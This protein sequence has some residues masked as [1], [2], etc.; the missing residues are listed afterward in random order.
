MASIPTT[1]IAMVVVKQGGPVVLDQSYPVPRIE[2]LKPGQVLVKVHYSGVCHSD[3]HLVDDAW[4]LK[5]PYPVVLGHEGA[6]ELVGIGA[7]TTTKL[8]IGDKVG[9]KWLGDSC[10][11]CEYCNKGHEQVCRS[12][13]N[14]GL[15]ASGTFQQYTVAA[16]T[17]LTPIPDNLPLEWAAPLLCAGITVYNALKKAGLEPAEYVAIP[18]AGGGLGHIALQY[19]HAM[20]YRTIAID[21]GADKEKLCKELKASFW[22][23]YKQEKDIVSAIQSITG[24][25]GAH[26]ALVAASVAD[27]YEQALLYIRPRGAVVLVGLPP[28][29]KMSI[30]IFPTALQEKRILGTLTSGRQQ[31]IEAL[32]FAAVAHIVPHIT[33]EPLANIIDVFKRFEENKVTGRIVIKIIQ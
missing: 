17:H 21:T 1:Q 18:G 7:H 12:A 13:T 25:L 16:A 32:N 30:D 19:A 26:A 23:D 22:I 33:I 29:A 10:L 28:N 14:T 2:D 5:P 20:G 3:Y 9:I 31:A 8:K 6:G 27:A 24:G 4:G 15:Y 11:Q